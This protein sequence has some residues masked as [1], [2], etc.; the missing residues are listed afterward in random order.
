MTGVPLR[1]SIGRFKSPNNGTIQHGHRH[2]PSGNAFRSSTE[3]VAPPVTS[4]DKAIM[5]YQIFAPEA[6]N[7]DQSSVGIVYSGFLNEFIELLPLQVILLSTT[8]SEQNLIT[9]KGRAKVST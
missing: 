8:V 4:V 5:T 9:S 3:F 1:P 6:A 7:G 2:L